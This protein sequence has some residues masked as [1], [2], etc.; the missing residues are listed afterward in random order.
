MHSKWSKLNIKNLTH[1]FIHLNKHL[2][3][4]PFAT[5]VQQEYIEPCLFLLHP[6]EYILYTQ[7]V[8]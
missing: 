6:G 5:H 1:Q 8:V 4:L 3:L 7:T 2:H